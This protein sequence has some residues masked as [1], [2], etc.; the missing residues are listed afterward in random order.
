MFY[1]ASFL[2]I[3]LALALLLGVAIG[4]RT[5]A[6][7]PQ[8]P[9]FTGWFRYALIALVVGIVLALLH[10]IPGRAGFWLETAVAFFVAY[11]IG[12]LA[13]GALQRLR[14]AA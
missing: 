11:L 5:E 7:G 1:D 8:E 13:G 3:W 14:A 12:C 2:W 4:W 10:L 6:S 9:W